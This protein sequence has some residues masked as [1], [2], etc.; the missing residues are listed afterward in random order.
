[1]HS[2]YLFAPFGNCNI[3]ALGLSSCELAE[4]PL[5]QARETVTGIIVI[6]IPAV[7]DCADERWLAILIRAN[8]G[9]F[10]T[11]WHLPRP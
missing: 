4:C 10:I 2:R 1:M 6:D 11:S 9:C 8:S 7:L 5:V 3:V